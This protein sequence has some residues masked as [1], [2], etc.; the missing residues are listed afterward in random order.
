LL[1]DLY[2]VSDEELQLI[3]SIRYVVV[4]RRDDGELLGGTLDSG[5]A[6]DG[7]CLDLGLTKRVAHRR[8][9]GRR[10]RGRGFVDSG[11]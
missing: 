9:C 6:R 10:R 8:C 2:L 4:E 5:R 7:R 3:V 11:R 1:H